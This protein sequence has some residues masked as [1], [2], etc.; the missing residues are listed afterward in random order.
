[1]AYITYSIS[2]DENVAQ[3]F[4]LPAIICNSL[5]KWLLIREVLLSA[6]K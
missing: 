6:R 5:Y 4:L 1:M 2:R 3:A